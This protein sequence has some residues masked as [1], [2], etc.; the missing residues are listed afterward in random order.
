M[1]YG[2]LFGVGEQVVDAGANT[3]LALTKMLHWF[4]PYLA[5]LMPILMR[6]LIPLGLFALLLFLINRK[7]RE[8]GRAWLQAFSAPSVY[9]T[10]MY[11]VI[12]FIAL[13]VTVVTADHRDLFSDRYY[14]ILLVPTAIFILFTFD[15]LIVPHLNVSPQQV[16]IGLVLIFALWSMYPFY[17][18]REYL[19]EAREEGEPSG[20]NM[21]N[22]R[23][24]REM[25]VVA[26]MQRIREEQPEEIFYSN[27]SDAVWFYTR[28]PVSPLPIVNDNPL[29]TY[30]GWPFENPG[31]II[32]FE[33]NE[34][35]HYLP[36]EKIGEFADV[37]LIYE[38][39]GGKIYYV[40]A[41]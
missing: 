23:T 38:G 12:Y 10:M 6:P 33:P 5:F 40:Q 15:K 11:A 19:L 28:K 20:A 41:R 35:K 2:T 34:Y 14:V 22:N 9:P 32:W 16:R 25:T 37:N 3:F 39:T 31:Y 24:Y 1:T 30:A 26:E 29:V 27:Y 17:S 36:P 18:F 13:A 7:S 8:N 4:V 21:F